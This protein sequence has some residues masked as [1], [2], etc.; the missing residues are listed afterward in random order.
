[1]TG[2]G[3]SIA[4]MVSWTTRRVRPSN[5]L[6]VLSV[7]KNALHG[8]ETSDLVTLGMIKIKQ[9]IDKTIVLS[10]SL[11]AGDDLGDP[12]QDLVRVH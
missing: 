4:A 9:I 11:V 5:P 6:S 2:K 3:T 12:V 1:M 7:L 10:E 8:S